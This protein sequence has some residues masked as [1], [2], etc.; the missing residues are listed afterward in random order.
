[1]D[2]E[3]DHIIYTILSL[4]EDYPISSPPLSNL[5][6]QVSPIGEL[7]NLLSIMNISEPPKVSNVLEQTLLELF[8][9]LGYQQEEGNYQSMNRSFSEQ[10]S[11]IAPDMNSRADLNNNQN[12]KVLKRK[13]CEAEMDD[14]KYS[15]EAVHNSRAVLSNAKFRKKT[16]YNREQTVFLQNQFD[17]NPYPDFVTRCRI[18][19]IA[20]IPEPRI[21]VWFQNRRARHLCKPN[22]FSEQKSLGTG[23]PSNSFKYNQNL[24]RSY[25]T[26]DNLENM[27]WPF[28]PSSKQS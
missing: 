18:A 15:M 20:G 5:N 3:L 25:R 14:T 1:M 8:T 27:G 28:N 7:P 16:I 2:T 10:I 6:N 24:R 11:Q 21:Q 13:M 17:L 4:E 12:Y 19:E 22:T 23:G 9:Y 26:T